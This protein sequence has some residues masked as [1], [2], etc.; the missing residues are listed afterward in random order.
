MV[1]DNHGLFIAE[2]RLDRFISRNSGFIIAGLISFA[3]GILRFIL[4]LPR[5]H[6]LNKGQGRA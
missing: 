6:L 5:G 2:V 4:A 3:N 1:L